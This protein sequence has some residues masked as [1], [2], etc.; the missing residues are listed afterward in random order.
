[1]KKLPII[2]LL[3]FIF[4]LNFCT[5][6]FKR[7]LDSLCI[8]CNN[9]SSD[10][11]KVVALGK[12]ANLFY[13]YKL[14][15]EGDS[16]LHD[17]LQIAELSDNNNLI[18]LALF[19][20]AITNISQSATAET[21]DKIIMFLQKG[22]DYAK[23]QNQYNYIALGYTRMA[24]ILRKREQ[25][26]KAL[27][28][29]SQALQVL[30]NVNSDSIKAV[31]YM[32]LGNVYIARAD[33]VSAVRNFN[34]A[35]DIALKLRSVPLQCDIYHC[36]AEMYFVFLNNK[37]IAKD[38]LKKS[39][40]LDKE[41]CFFDGQIRDY[42][43][44]YR[45]TDEISYLQKAIKLSDSLKYTK[46]ILYAKRV[47]LSFYY[48]IEKNSDKA[49]HYLNT[50]PDLK[51][52]YINTSIGNYYSTIGHIYYYTNK[53][54]SALHYYKHA[55]YD[56][57]QNFGENYSR[58]LFI[59]IARCYQQLNDL[60][61]ATAY[62]LKAL[63]LSK[64]TNDARSMAS[65]SA[66]L[67]NLY[68]QQ[69]DHKQAFYYLAQ[70]KKYEDSLGQ[71]SK[72]RDI[73]LLDVERENRKHEDELRLETLKENRKRDV[74]YMAISIAI[75]VIFVGFLFIG[76]FPVS[77]LTIKLFGY[78]FFISLFE[79]IVLLIDNM[80]LTKAVHG[81]PLKLWV[82][83]IVLIALLVPLQHYMEHNLIKFLASRKLL[84]ARTRF[85]F[86]SLSINKWWQNMKKPASG[87]EAG[88]E[89]DTAVL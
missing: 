38:F 16:V 86:K 4:S 27:Y 5:A 34:N 32:E 6:Q 19:S 61:N 55:E 12:I 13:T 82:I 64:K 57:V 35:F 54:D 10:S 41:N 14:N 62:Y 77:K 83:K 75:C 48:L 26:D 68:E 45:V 17:Q 69:E 88:I 56:F 46:Y 8:V 81:E 66:A 74:Q 47:M 70:S 42:I 50:E 73:A 59:Y 58:G 85:S 76:M 30:P 28:S 80:L 63:S 51:E 25:N 49:L 9:T 78:F 7:Q 2:L 11:D 87:I 29:A 20:D 40:R 67:S 52:S 39:L 44:L 3:L 65:V 53:F 60:S 23:S 84:E 79:F 15:H 31:I 33:A 72:A 18:L 36:F 24:S 43:D 71:L 1:M 89:E 21:F 22:I 37:D